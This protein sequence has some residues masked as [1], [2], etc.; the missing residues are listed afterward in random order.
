[1]AASTPDGTSVYTVRLVKGARTRVEEDAIVSR[2]VVR[3][4]LEALEIETKDG[5]QGARA[6]THTHTHTTHMTQPETHPEQGSRLE[7]KEGF[8]GKARFATLRVSYTHVS[9][10]LS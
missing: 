10:R 2:L 3:A 7:T 4:I 1:M 5:F 9:G 6:R 8:H